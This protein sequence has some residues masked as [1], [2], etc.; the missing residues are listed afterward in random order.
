MYHNVKFSGLGDMGGWPGAPGANRYSPITPSY[1]H[2][3]EHQQKMHQYPPQQVHLLI[4]K[5][6]NMHNIPLYFI[7]II[8]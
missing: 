5:N 6:F 2:S 3:Y 7:Y 1:R 4:S 8:R